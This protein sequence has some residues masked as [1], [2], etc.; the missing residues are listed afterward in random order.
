[1]KHKEEVLRDKRLIWHQAWVKVMQW[2]FPHCRHEPQGS[3]LVGKKKVV[4]VCLKIGHE[5][6]LN[7]CY[8]SSWFAI[9][10]L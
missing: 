2:I 9:H 8:K 7:L 6:F 3:L 10:V 1:M 4:F 5:C